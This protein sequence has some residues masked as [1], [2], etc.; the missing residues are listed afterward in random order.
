MSETKKS[1]SPS[2]K[3]KIPLLIALAVLFLA[4]VGGVLF[5]Y[6]SNE[7]D[8]HGVSQEERIEAYYH[9]HRSEFCDPQKAVLP[10]ED[11][12][13]LQDYD[14]RI[15]YNDGLYTVEISSQDP[16]E[17]DAALIAL[18]LVEATMN[19]DADGYNSLFAQEYLEQ[20]GRQGRFHAQK[21]YNIVIERGS[22]SQD[23]RSCRF[24]V[25]YAIKDN[26]ATLRRDI[27][28]NMSRPMILTVVKEDGIYR[29]ASLSYRFLQ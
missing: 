14:R 29:I 7:G 3:K 17:D 22:R 15:L 8:F 5:Y 4:V 13:Y 27:V 21:I 6:F 1:T 11:E 18:A 25:S 2:G 19:G 16:P 24:T 26:D 9:A 23:G 12:E 10:S 28:P 20:N